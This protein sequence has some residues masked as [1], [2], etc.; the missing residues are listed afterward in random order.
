MRKQTL[1]IFAATTAVILVCAYAGLSASRPQASFG[2]LV[3]KPVVDEDNT[4]VV[5]FLTR[6]QWVRRR[7]TFRSSLRD[8][9]KAAARELTAKGYKQSQVWRDRKGKVEMVQFGLTSSPVYT[10]E[11]YVRIYKDTRWLKSTEQY[12]KDGFGVSGEDNPGWVT[13]EV[14]FDRKLT[15]VDKLLV[16]L[17]SG[18]SL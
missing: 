12:T 14:V 16:K 5:S 9:Q 6:Q 10:N 2:F 7:Y 17:E 18:P 15:L 11:S 4:R 1:I 3:G 13:V 8:A